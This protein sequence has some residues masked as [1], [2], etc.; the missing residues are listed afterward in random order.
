MEVEENMISRL[1]RSWH[2]GLSTSWHTPW[3]HSWLNNGTCSSQ[4]IPAV[5]SDSGRGHHLLQSW[6]TTNAPLT[7]W[8]SCNNQCLSSAGADV[9][10]QPNRAGTWWQ[11]GHGLTNKGFPHLMEKPNRSE[12][13]F[14]DT[15]FENYDS[16]PTIE[17]MGFLKSIHNISCSTMFKLFYITLKSIET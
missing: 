15:P 8:S 2:T 5:T 9:S 10:L 3:A 17:K 11:V 13:K 1:A 6:E 4:A 12:Q 7:V 16:Y 14:S